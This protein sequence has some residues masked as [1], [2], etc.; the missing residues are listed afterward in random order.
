M[1]TNRLSVAGFLRVKFAPAHVLHSML[2][3]RP[4]CAFKIALRWAH[5]QNDQINAETV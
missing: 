4:Q 3:A 1:L 2:N 5:A